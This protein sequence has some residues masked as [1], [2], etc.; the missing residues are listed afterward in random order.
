MVRSALDAY[1][2]AAE[3]LGL[4][5]TS[6]GP[7]SAV[8]VGDQDA[9][10]RILD[11]LL[12]NAI[13]YTPRGGT[14]VV[15]TRV[16]G[17][18]LRLSVKDT[19][20]GIAPEDHERIF[21]RF[22][23]A[24][25]PVASGASSSGIGLALVRELARAH[26]GSVAVTSTVGAGSTFDVT[27]PCAPTDELLSHRRR[28]TSRRA[29]LAEATPLPL[30]V[31]SEAL[32]RRVD[33]VRPLAPEQA[34][35]VLVAEDNPDLRGQIADV[36]APHYRMV[37]VENGTQALAVFG[38][39]AIDLVV[40]DLVMPGLDGIELVRRL[41]TLPGAS[42]VPFLLLTAVHDRKT[43]VG[44]LDA[45]ADDYLV[46][47]F[48]EAELLGRLRTQLRLRELAKS[49]AEAKGQAALGLVLSSMAH[50]LRNPINVLVNGILPLRESLEAAGLKD[51]GI[52]ELVAALEDAGRRVGGLS[53]QLLAYRRS[54]SDEGA[55]VR[56]P[57]LI[58]ESLRLLQPR[59][60]GVALETH[61][62]TDGAVRGSGQ[63]LSQVVVNLVEN[64][65]QATNGKGPVGIEVREESEDVVVDVW[66]RGP[67]VPPENRERIFDPFFSTKRAGEGTGLG[68][69]IS[70]Q[71]AERHGGRLSLA[72]SEVGARFRLTLPR[73]RP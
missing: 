7:Q 27:L 56:V 17:E 33:A 47:P 19:G 65:I 61:I 23:R 6:E 24:S 15:S 5:L 48:L 53:E 58:D 8:V 11:N 73:A 67:G 49:L 25:T 71:I 57:E 14:V 51:P 72:P 43:L 60:A 4:S 34:P 31:G 55:R 37:L 21:E 9:I 30:A 26:G 44:A 41:R 16:V 29:L 64:A 66:D 50:E 1:G 42:L 39:Q 35:L 38:R 46:K 68:L 28:G 70:R 62:G 22:E 12:G 54:A 3:R 20:V 69:A 10:G 63:V 13:K 52:V 59:L 18:T 45:G 2:P 32:A 40:S 36:L